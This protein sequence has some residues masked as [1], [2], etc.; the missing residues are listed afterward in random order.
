MALENAK[1]CKNRLFSSLTSFPVAILDFLEKR[2]HTCAVFFNSLQD[3]LNRLSI[4]QTVFEIW[5]VCRD[6]YIA[7][8][9]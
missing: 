6:P 9:V 2:D 1:N 4:S 3:A 7:L 5:T 8:K